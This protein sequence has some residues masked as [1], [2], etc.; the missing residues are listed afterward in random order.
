MT[1]AAYRMEPEPGAALLKAS[2]QDHYRWLRLEREEVDTIL[3]NAIIGTKSSFAAV[4]VTIDELRLKTQTRSVLEAIHEGMLVEPDEVADPE[5]PQE[6]ESLGRLTREACNVL[7]SSSECDLN[8]AILM[9]LKAV[10]RGAGFERV[11]F[12]F[13]T[14][15]RTYIEGRL[16]LGDDVDSLLERFKFR[17][18]LSGGPVARSLLAGRVSLVDTAVDP[19]NQIARVFGSSYLGLY[20]VVVADLVVGC[21]F[22]DCQKGRPKTDDGELQLIEQLRD[23]LVSALTRL[24]RGAGRQ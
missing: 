2:L 5:R 20:P 3:A 7:Q 17:M 11:I 19:L 1:A 15:D 21:I 10:H 9:V 16:G 6:P 23:A 13:V 22:M 12:A 18:A 4:G 24:R 8:T 14:Q